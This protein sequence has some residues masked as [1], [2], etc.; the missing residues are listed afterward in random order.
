MIKNKQKCLGWAR[1]E[2]KEEEEVW[3]WLWKR[4]SVKS[5]TNFQGIERGKRWYFVLENGSLEQFERL[6]IEKGC[7]LVLLGRQSKAIC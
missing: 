7:S 1:V 2:K 4:E 3:R 6:W 5:K